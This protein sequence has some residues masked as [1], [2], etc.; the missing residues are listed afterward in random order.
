MIKKSLALLLCIGMILG[1]GFCEKNVT[2]QTTY[3]DL[4]DTVTTFSAVFPSQQSFDEAAK[5]VHQQLKYYHQLFDIYHTYDGMSNLKT[6]NDNAGIKPVKV[7]RTLMDLLIFSKEVYK[8]T[9]GKVNIAMGSVLSVW[10]SYRD[11]GTRIPEA[12]LLESA[13]QYTKIDNL[14]IDTAAGTVYITEKRTALDVGSVAKGYA[15]KLIMEYAK[16]LGVQSGIVNL[17]GNVGV[18]GEKKKNQP[19][20]IGIEDPDQTKDYLFTL[21]V[22]DTSVVTSGD[23]QRFYTVDGV[24]YCHII[25]PSTL[26]PARY[27]KS[28]SVVCSDSALADALS[29][30]LFITD[31]E[32]GK[33]M[34]ENQKNCEAVW[35]LGE[36]NYRYSSGFEKMI[37]Q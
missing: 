36:G 15:C 8:Q 16:R 32:T 34:I 33:K 18:I 7:D 24:R 28:V 29:T 25:D 9:D 27:Y 17:G 21:G 14:I 10:H 12:S 30:Y 2:Y 22:K 26:Y 11:E 1:L 31:Y 23:Y 37:L 4:F 3:L 13:A 20:R 19:Y 35:V 5:K 6:I